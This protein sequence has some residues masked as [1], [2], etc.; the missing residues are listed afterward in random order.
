VLGHQIQ[1]G[2]VGEHE[3][4]RRDCR[5]GVV[6]TSLVFLMSSRAIIALRLRTLIAV[7]RYL[8]RFRS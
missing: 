6:A 5:F 3:V 1:D 7:V 4:R 8:W 2:A